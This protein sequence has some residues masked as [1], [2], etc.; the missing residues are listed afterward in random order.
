[1]LDGRIINI[2]FWTNVGGEISNYL[3]YSFRK[4][5]D[6]RQTINNDYLSEKDES[7]LGVGELFSVY[8]VHL[9]FIAMIYSCITCLNFKH[10]FKNKSIKEY[11]NVC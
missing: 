3:L 11:L 9:N 8:F 5:L 2:V 1:M 7:K 4:D 10:F 6:T